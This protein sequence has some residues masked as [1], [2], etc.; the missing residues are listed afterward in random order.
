MPLFLEN[1]KIDLTI[2]S[3]DEFDKNIV[4]GG[5][6]NSQY[7]KYKQNFEA[8]FND[9]VKPLQ[10]S[11]SALFEKNEYNSDT[12]KEL[13]NELRESKSKDKNIVIYKKI[14]DL[15]KA[16]KHLSPKAK[17]LE[18]NLKPIYEEQKRF[19]EEYIENN[20]TIVSY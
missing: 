20:P 2:H 18:A 8:E 4:S 16:D 19:Q 6:L 11:I 10:D 1:E 15:R 3:E 12:V 17:V 9:R 14:D 13:Y 5:K 7:K